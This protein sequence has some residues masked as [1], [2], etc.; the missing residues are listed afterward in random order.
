VIEHL[1]RSKALSGMIALI[2]NLTG[3]ETLTAQIEN[4]K[5]TLN[6]NDPAAAIAAVHDLLARSEVLLSSDS[7]DWVI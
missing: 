4:E 1:I 6:A 7:A 5:I 3:E 2:V